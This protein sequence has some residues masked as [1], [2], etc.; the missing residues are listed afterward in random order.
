MVLV[1]KGNVCRNFIAPLFP[2]SGAAQTAGTLPPTH[3][4]SL[5]VCVCSAAAI[6]VFVGTIIG[7]RVYKH[8]RRYR[9]YDRLAV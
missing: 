3:C 9:I 1:V 7:L 2:D 5:C 4:V 6:A 8:L